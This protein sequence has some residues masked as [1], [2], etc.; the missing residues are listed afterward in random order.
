MW[1]HV[2]LRNEFT[3]LKLVME[4]MIHQPGFF[5]FWTSSGNKQYVNLVSTVSYVLRYCRVRDRLYQYCTLFHSFP[6]NVSKRERRMVPSYVS[7]CFIPQICEHH[8]HAHNI[9]VHNSASAF[10][11]QTLL[12]FRIFNCQR[13]VKNTL[14]VLKRLGTW[15]SVF[16]WWT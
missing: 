6:L 1:V 2:P 12:S 3:I 16:K 14:G 15:I 7:P 10:H 4:M 13:P 11:S 5:F 8:K 9:Y